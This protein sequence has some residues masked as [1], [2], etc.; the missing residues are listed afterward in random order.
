M[1]R[2]LILGCAGAGKSTLARRLGALLDLPV[3]HLDQLWWT[4]GWVSR[5]P[6]EFDRLLAAELAK[7]RWIMDGNYDRTLPLRLARA[8]GVILLDYP[9]RLCLLGVLRRV[10]AS[11]GRVRPDMAPGCPERLDWSFLA[12]VWRFRGREGRRVRQALA[13]WPG[14]V[15]TLRSRRECGRLLSRLAQ[16]GPAD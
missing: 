7:D 14:T 12:W 10:R 4:P 11:R 2:I 13:A 1:E 15:Y 3:V 16:A 6:A 5:S 8:D 9:R